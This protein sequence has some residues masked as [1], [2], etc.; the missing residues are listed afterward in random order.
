[1]PSMR[2]DQALV[3]RGLV[4]SRTKA[5]RRI[6]AGD[7]SVGGAIQTKH[8]FPVDDNVAIV[9][10]GEEDYVGRGAHKLLAALDEWDL[11]V[12]GSSSVD[13]G[14][15]TGGFT[16]VLLERGAREVVAVDVGHGQLHPSLVGDPR[17]T[18]CEGVNVRYLTSEWRESLGLASIDWVVADLSF[19]SLTHIF[20]PVTEALGPASWVCL[21]KPQFEVGRT[22]VT[23]GIVTDPSSHVDAVEAVI[24][25]AGE[26][27]LFPAGL[28][29]SPITGEAGNREYLCWF[30]PTRGRNQTQ[31]SEHIH[32]VTHS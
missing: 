22:G 23:E 17:V 18:L 25:A 20:A 31:W 32:H 29:L 6:D 8:A 26:C 11:D 2:L 15:S 10:S 12:R 1:M 4:E 14:A 30:T 21:V 9:V 19:I 24:H 27:G 28:M 3:S 13:L 16:Q 7:V 5:Q